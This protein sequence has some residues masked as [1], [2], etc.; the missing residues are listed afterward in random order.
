MQTSVPTFQNIHTSQAYNYPVNYVNVN[1][2][3]YVQPI[4]NIHIIPSYQPQQIQS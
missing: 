2:V 4:P 1:K 3:N